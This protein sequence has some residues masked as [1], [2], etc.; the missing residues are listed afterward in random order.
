MPP[1]NFGGATVLNTSPT[2]TGAPLSPTATPGTNTTQIAT[3]AFV[4][5]GIGALGTMSSQNA[6]AVAI[7]GGSVTGV[8]DITVADGGTG[9][10]R[11]VLREAPAQDF[12]HHK[13][14]TL[15]SR[16]CRDSTAQ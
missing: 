4:A 15:Y 14:H 3:T 12:L 9:Q 13:L 1:P 10:A 6:N 7:T 16:M 2:L 11:R 8:T 5:A